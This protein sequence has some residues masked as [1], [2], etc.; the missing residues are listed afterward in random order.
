MVRK[1]RRA[2]RLGER[3]VGWL[4]RAAEEAKRR[5]RE[6]QGLAQEASER[7]WRVESGGWRVEGGEWRVESREWGGAEPWQQGPWDAIT[8]SRAAIEF[9]R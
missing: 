4:A 5:K 2:G 7:P 8:K 6:G 9:P 3:S 1:K